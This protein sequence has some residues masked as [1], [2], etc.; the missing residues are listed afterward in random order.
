MKTPPRCP[1]CG[2]YCNECC[3][4]PSQ[5]HL[6]RMDEA[7]D[8]YI[9]HLESRLTEIAEICSNRPVGLVNG[10]ILDKIGKIAIIIK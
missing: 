10:D 3:G 6:G 1:T 4:D 5:Y 2:K 9:D 8:D 7:I